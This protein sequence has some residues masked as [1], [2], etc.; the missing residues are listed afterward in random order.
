MSLERLFSKQLRSM[1][2]MER[3]STTGLLLSQVSTHPL[4][5]LSDVRRSG[6]GCRGRAMHLLGAQ[7]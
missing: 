6:H 2:V 3:S 7:G 4:V 5:S 1:R